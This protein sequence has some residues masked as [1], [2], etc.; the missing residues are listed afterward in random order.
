VPEAPGP[1]RWGL[2]HAALAFLLAIVLESLGAQ[3]AAQ[4]VGYRSAPGRVVPLAVTAGALIGL[5]LGLAGGAVYASRT[6]GRGRL[7]DDYGWRISWPFD[8]VAGVV[9]GAGT[10]LVLIPL[11]Y[12]PFEHADPTLRHRLEAPAKADTAGVHGGWQ[13]AA[14]FVFL[15]VGAPIVEELFF[16]GLL[17]RSLER[18]LG[19]VVAVGGSAV[20]FGFAHFQLLQLPAL[21]LFGVVLGLLAERSHRLGA[22][23]VAHAV[24][25]AITV[26]TLTYGR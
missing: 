9:A 1:S 22:G 24:F 5:W 11:L 18:R 25:N 12:L 2:G 14:L 7:G 6:R 10:Q 8:A 20:A 15:A 21:I 13:I 26:I 16:R 3:M 4:A 23:I 17:L 19:P